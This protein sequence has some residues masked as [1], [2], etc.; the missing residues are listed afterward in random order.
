MPT[1]AFL[2]LPSLQP[3]CLSVYHGI[4]IF[5]FLCSLTLEVTS[6]RHAD[7][8]LSLHLQSCLQNL[9][10]VLH[11]QTTCLWSFITVWC[12]GPQ[13]WNSTG[14][15]PNTFSFH[16][17]AYIRYRLLSPPEYCH[18]WI[19]QKGMNWIQVGH[20]KLCA[21]CKNADW[22]QAYVCKI[23]LKKSKLALT[24]L[25]KE[26]GQPP[27]AGLCANVSAL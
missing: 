9:E 27:R 21:H 2:S 1:L 8:N 20:Q 25:V 22:Q 14:Y 16:F 3:T 19:C 7:K 11:Q 4:Y 5:Q 26:D 15:G 10:R 17:S 24:Q 6:T 13:H 18:C 12:G 23:R